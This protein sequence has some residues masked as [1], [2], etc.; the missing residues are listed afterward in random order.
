MATTSDLSKN[1]RLQKT[2]D[3][4]AVWAWRSAIRGGPSHHVLWVSNRPRNC[5]GCIVPSIHML[6]VTFI[7]HIIAQHADS[8]CIRHRMLDHL[9]S[10]VGWLLMFSTVH[11]M[12]CLPY[13]CIL[14]Q[15]VVFIEVVYQSLQSVC[16]ATA[17]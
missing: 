17:H 4:T 9:H 3:V 5:R 8:R 7:L 2:G 11:Q 13:D 16:R 1:V 10:V 6:Y 14:K 12:S 15:G